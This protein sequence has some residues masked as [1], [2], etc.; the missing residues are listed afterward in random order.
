MRP[1]IGAIL[2]VVLLPQTVF[3][4]DWVKK[5]S[6]AKAGEKW[7]V[8]FE[9]DTFTDVEVAIVDAKGKVVR[10]LAA[11]VLGKKTPPP[12][13]ANAKAQALEWD[14]KDDYGEAAKGGPFKARVRAGMGVKLEKIIGGDPYAWYSKEMNSGNHAAWRLSGMELKPDGTVYVLGN[15]TFTGPPALRQY[16]AKGTYMRTVFPPPAG[17]PVEKMKGW[18][19]SVREDGS[20]CP[21]FRQL[22]NP[23]ITTTFFAGHRGAIAD[24]IPSPHKDKVVVSKV[25]GKGQSFDLLTVHRDGY[26]TA[27][28]D[29]KGKL[30]NE[31]SPVASNGKRS[32]GISG[33]LYTCLSPDRKSI[34]LSGI[35]AQKSESAATD[36]FWRDGQVFKVDVATGKAKP[37]FNIGKVVEAKHD[38]IK[39]P[40]G[41]FRMSYSA[42]HGVAA[43]EE[44]VFVCDRLNKRVVV[45]DREA[46]V[47][48]EI[49]LLHPD[50]VA[51]G[52]KPGVLY[53]TTRIGGDDSGKGEVKLLKYADWRKDTKP[54][55]AVSLCK[56]KSQQFVSFNRSHL[57]V[58]DKGGD[59]THVWVGFTFLSI[60]IYK[61][62]GD[63]L[64][65][66]KDFY[67]AG[68]QRCLDFSRLIVDEKTEDVY[69]A[70]SFVSLFRANDWQNPTLTRCMSAEGKPVHATGGAVALDSRNRHLYLIGQKSKPVIRYGLSGKHLAPADT[71]TSKAHLPAPVLGV[72]WKIGLGLST[73]GFDIA[74][75]G[76][77]ARFSR[78]KT[79][80]GK[81]MS[82]SI[83]RAGKSEPSGSIKNVAKKY[84]GCIAF[85]RKG[86]LYAGIVDK[87]PDNIPKGFKGD[88]NYATQIGRIY[89]Y[90]PTGSLAKGNLYP[91]APKAPAK[92]YNVHF[93]DLGGSFFRRPSYFAVDGYG[94]VI[95]PNSLASYVGVIDNEGN[96]VLRFGTYG[97]RDSTGGLEGDLV[98]TKDIPM[99]FPKCVDVTDDYIYVGDRANCRMLRIKK[100]F[101]LT[102]AGG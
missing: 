41:G 61:D 95:Y 17:K 46:K 88:K 54:A 59:G 82:L 13:A 15:S 7:T 50:A 80:R 96:E 37:F 92:V 63:R 73:A 57:I 97:N 75:D 39:S 100:T 56:F 94:R 65:L 33:P 14:G 29:M 81:A 26:I 27:D 51:V 11:G 47:I 64:E 2:A 91:T 58:N 43:T 102:A 40:I 62:Q 70:D 18:G 99:A 52:A 23:D 74:P 31:P 20:Y 24:L 30:V 3:A 87:A 85:D 77:I 4:L 25:A 45:L 42:V 101:K 8:S 71:K 68:P 60:R 93:G 21:R 69:V 90:A 16:D 72:G 19:I 44:N 67:E 89:K 55:V 34:Y 98:P 48:K 53:V 78:P 10:H 38:R 79:G 1:Y 12:L 32:W 66:V 22:G 49:P 86:N 35:Y 9:L 76:N 36:G 83:V 28:A 5:P 6:M 84:A